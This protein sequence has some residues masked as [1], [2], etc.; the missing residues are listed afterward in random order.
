MNG[1]SEL[2]I[3][4]RIIHGTGEG[5]RFI[6]MPEYL[7]QFARILGC[8]PHAGT[9]NVRVIEG[10]EQL[11]HE[12]MMRLPQEKGIAINGFEKEGKH[13]L[14]GTAV[15]CRVR[16]RERIL[17]GLLYFPEKTVHPHDVLEVISCER[18]LNFA[19][20]GEYIVIEI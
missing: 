11:E 16:L 8:E 4:G 1:H 14:S 6:S 7:D 17:Q 2:R 19:E 20:M 5:K 13:Y 18:I 9:L 10:L 12:K 3:T 15:P